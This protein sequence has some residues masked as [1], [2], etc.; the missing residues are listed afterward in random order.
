MHVIF[1]QELEGCPLP[2]S[3][4]GLQKI[5][6]GPL[7]FLDLLE[8]RLGI[9]PHFPNQL[10]RI[11]AYRDSLAAASGN[12]TSRFY[13]RSFEL[14]PFG[15]AKIILRWRDELKLAGWKSS[16]AD[17]P[18]RL[19]DLADVDVIFQTTAEGEIDTASRLGRISQ[20]LDAEELTGIEQLDLVDPL[21]S[22]PATWRNVLERL[23]FSENAWPIPLEPL[24]KD[25]S[26]LR[27]IQARL[28]GSAEE[29]STADDSIRIIQGNVIS[30]SAAAAAQA[31]ADFESS[32]SALLIGTRSDLLP[33]DEALRKLDSPSPGSRAGESA[34]PISQIVTALLRVH[35]GSFNPQAWLEFFLCPISPISRQLARKMARAIADTPSRENRKWQESIDQTLE[36]IED[37]GAKERLQKQVHEWLSPEEFS[38]TASGSVLSYTCRKLAQWMNK[39]ASG[40]DAKPEQGH[41]RSVARAA[42]D[43]ADL[44][45]RSPEWLN[46][47]TAA[48]NA[49]TAQLGAPAC[50]SDPAHVLE[51]VDH[52]FWWQPDDPSVRRLPWNVEEKQWLDDNNVVFPEEN[53]VRKTAQQHRLRP[54]L[55]ARK[56]ISLY[57]CPSVGSENSALPAILIRLLAEL[58][59][60]NSLAASDLIDTTA[61]TRMP[62]P[63]KR[64]EWNISRADLITPRESESFSS[65]NKFIYSPW[66]WVLTYKARL[67]SGNVTDLR[68]TD[69]AATRGGL[70]HSFVENLLSPEIDSSA[71]APGLLETL[72]QRIFSENSEVNWTS[73]SEEAVKKWVT[74][75]WTEILGTQAA[76]YLT[77]GFEASRSELLYLAKNGIWKLIV[78]LRDAGI[79]RVTC[80]EHI[81][82]I[83]FKDSLLGGFIDLRVENE[84]GETGVIDLN[85]GGIS[86]R[87]EELEKGRFLQLAIYGKLVQAKHGHAPHCAYFIFSSGGSLI[88]NSNAFFPG[89]EVIGS[90]PGWETCWAEFESLWNQRRAELDQG[91]LDVTLSSFKPKMSLPHWTHK[92][93]DKYSDFLNLGGWD[94]GA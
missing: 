41:Y 24:A 49:S 40:L 37:S 3:T 21:E 55:L 91:K 76:H 23:P 48:V 81:S 22:F 31:L 61:V 68:I 12:S 87:R 74:D 7:G 53:A 46:T 27:E 64:Q 65:L 63:A 42:G 60:G 57:S 93:P 9:A 4:H 73:V 32:P 19:T 66:D 33:V 80:E 8:M 59:S 17:Q 5:V 84:A 11:A 56:S 75:Q 71:A 44:F 6:V 29:I 30:Q 86:G 20:A 28:L 52:I 70:L 14:D 85:L 36:S 82:E 88:A 35:W 10:A 18:N 58:G 15:S 92:E 94:V 72:I 1:G 89:A 25:G 51:P 26:L 34:A 77:P 83:P 47:T 39:R 69:D 54:I 90:D 13:S 43:L 2:K 50:V 38:E 79:V 78:Q 45:D 62:L 16:I 67:K